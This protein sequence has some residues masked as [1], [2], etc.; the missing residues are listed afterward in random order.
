L[1]FAGSNLI[2][3]LAAFNVGVELGQLLVVAFAVP[4]LALLYKRVLSERTG[5]ILLSAIV[6]HQAW[7]WMTERFSEF[8]A[9]ELAMPVMDRAFAVDAMRFVMLLMIATGAMW[10]MSIVAARFRSMRAAR[11]TLLLVA[12]SLPALWSAPL[13]AQKPTRT[14]MTGVY[15]AKQAEQ[16]REVFNGSCMGCHTAA[17]HTGPAFTVRWIGAPLSDLLDYISSYM[18]KAAPGSL[19]EDE[20]VWVT[21]YLLKLNGMPPGP[22]PMSGDLKVLETIRIDSVVSPKR[23][24]GLSQFRPSLQHLLR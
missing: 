6:A 17:S 2:T 8:R 24:P 14:T 22:T 7:H 21:A 9:H 19:S 11:T 5:A 4:V 3:A 13:G 18:P 16:G 15:T 20:Y 12:V 10:A 1:Q 23:L